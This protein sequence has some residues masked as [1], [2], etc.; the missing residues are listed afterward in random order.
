MTV[1][2]FAATPATGVGMV[3]CRAST[4]RSC[5]GEGDDQERCTIGRVWLAKRAKLRQ[6]CEGW[7]VLSALSVS[8]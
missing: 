8:F 2:M 5:Q 7:V 6:T 3:V 4:G 1:M